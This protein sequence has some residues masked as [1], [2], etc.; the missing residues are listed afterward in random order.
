VEMSPRKLTEINKTFASSKIKNLTTRGRTNMSGGIGMAAQEIR[1][2]ESPHDVQAI[3]LLTDGQANDG[4][5]DIEGIVKLTKGC[6]GSGPRQNSVPIHCFGYGSDHNSDMLKEISESTEGGTYYFVDNDTDVSSAFGDAL[7]GVLSV[8]A[9]NV[10]VTLKVPQEAAANGVSILDVKHDNATKNEDGSFSI[11]LND[12][13]AEESRDI[14]FEVS[15]SDVSNYSPVIHTTSSLAYLDTV[16]SKLVQSDNFNGSIKRP[17]GNEI[18]IINDHVSLQ[19]I[20][21]KTTE[22]IAEAKR[23]ADSGNLDA[24]KTMINSMI[25]QLQKEDST[26]QKSDFIIQMLSEL[27]AI[28]SGLSS[29]VSYEAQG[30][31]YMQSRLLTHKRQ[32]CSEADESSRNVYKNS[33]KAT[34]SMRMKAASMSFKK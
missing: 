4:I 24:S 23:L 12:F 3:F 30:G 26:V 34:R 14:I 7:G 17:L 1:S 27:N 13:Y 2:I 25:D 6:L 10:R 29:R 5:S 33:F 18:S 15:L 16:N 22:V 20:R 32:R 28:I 9:Q 19:C 8:V 21:I 31:H 11:T